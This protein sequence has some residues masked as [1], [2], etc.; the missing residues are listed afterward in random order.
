MFGLDFNPANQLCVV[1]VIECQAIDR[2]DSQQKAT[3]NACKK[4]KVEEVHVVQ[5]PQQQIYF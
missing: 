1:P 2:S 4:I 3:V 5:K